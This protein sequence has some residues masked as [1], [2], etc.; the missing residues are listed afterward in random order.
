[1]NDPV[2]IALIA[3]VCAVTSGSVGACGAVAAAKWGKKNAATLHDIRIS[4]NGRLDQLIAASHA[5]GQIE[6]RDNQRAVEIRA[7]D[8][9]HFE[10]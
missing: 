5:S 9:A 1:M 3:G 8:K 2:L 6:E 4:I 10:P 7:A